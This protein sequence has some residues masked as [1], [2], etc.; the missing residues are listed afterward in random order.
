MLQD[1]DRRVVPAVLA[2]LARL[3][4]PNLA[5]VALA[6]LK[7][8]DFAVRAAASRLVGELKPAG[9]AEALREAPARS[10]RRTRPSTRAPPS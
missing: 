4:A 5:A 6:Q 7:E 3:K 10:P 9:G 8:P 1:E 2:A